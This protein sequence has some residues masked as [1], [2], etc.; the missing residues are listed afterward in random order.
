M[1]DLIMWIECGTLYTD[2]RGNRTPVVDGS[3]GGGRG[4]QATGSNVISLIMSTV[5]YC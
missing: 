2:V 1:Y 5:F 3:G 4:Q